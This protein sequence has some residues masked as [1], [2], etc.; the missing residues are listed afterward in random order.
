M[1]GGK[2]E[3]EY[4]T[5]LRNDREEE[6]T[7]GS[8]GTVQQGIKQFVYARQLYGHPIAVSQWVVGEWAATAVGYQSYQG[9]MNVSCSTLY[10]INVRAVF[11]LPILLYTR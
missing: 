2:T 6:R 9:L 3:D 11:L 8:G 4:S 10:P 1:A 7:R 5:R